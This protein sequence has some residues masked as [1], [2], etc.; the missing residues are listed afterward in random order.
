MSPC[1]RL[2][3]LLKKTAE[4]RAELSGPFVSELSEHRQSEDD[5]DT[6]T[7]SIIAKKKQVDDPRAISA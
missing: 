7:R 3:A 2:P 4:A 6:S 5:I 1:I